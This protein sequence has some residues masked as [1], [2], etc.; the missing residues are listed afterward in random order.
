MDRRPGARYVGA[1]RP[2]H[3]A[4]VLLCVLGAACGASRDDAPAPKEPA[5][6]PAANAGASA[7]PAPAL[8]VL[9][10]WN[11]AAA[12]RDAAALIQLYAEDA[13]VVPASSGVEVSGGESIVN[14][15]FRPFWSAFPDLVSEPMLT[16]V[17]GDVVVA[18]ERSRG[19]HRGA[20]MG[21]PPTGKKTSFYGL[22]VDVIENGAIA[23]QTLYADNLNFMG[24]LGLYPGRHRAY[25]A[26][27][28]AAAGTHVAGSSE[29][30]ADN[31]ALVR[32]YLEGL[33]KHQV[34]AA[35]YAAD[36]LLSNRALPADLRGSDAIALELRRFLGAFSDL[37][38]DID[39]V[40]AAGDWV[41]ATYVMRG[42][43]NGPLGDIRPTGKAIELEAAD[44]YRI[45]DGH[46]AE[47]WVFYDGMA[48]L[49]Q[50]G[51]LNLK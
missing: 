3:A 30:E 1:M 48:L 19:T 10:R 50:L 21:M 46:I 44:L 42:T 34:G 6:R 12:A 47:R 36:A 14:K 9:E 4:S 29:R 37:S 20:M 18:V 15:F 33:G 45:E 17:D 49:A 13:V 38:I 28:I 16:L 35:S 22:A 40:W 39:K 32:R 2:V 5:A 7:A 43:H 8:A 24:Q 23:R 31:A 11:R 41:V 27:P 25:D 51:K 26:A